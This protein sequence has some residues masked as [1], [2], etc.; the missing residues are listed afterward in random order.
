[1]EKNRHSIWD[2]SIGWAYGKVSKHSKGRRGSA[3]NNQRRAARTTKANR[4]HAR[5]MKK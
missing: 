3:W 5:R 2:R 4:K 1:M